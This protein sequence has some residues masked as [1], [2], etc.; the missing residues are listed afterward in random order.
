MAKAQLDR[1]I[2]Y[3]AANVSERVAQNLFETLVHSTDR[4]I[5]FYH[6][7]KMVEVNPIYRVLIEGHYMIIYS[8]EDEYIRVAFLFDSRQ[9]RE[10][11]LAF[12]T[13]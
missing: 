11:L 8:V 13:P 4:L 12:L 9:D 2:D 6:L 10:T 7:G 3:Y 1:I 5:N